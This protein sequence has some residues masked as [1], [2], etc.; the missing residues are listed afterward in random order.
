MIYYSLSWW[1]LNTGSYVKEEVIPRLRFLE[2]QE[3]LN[4][5]ADYILKEEDCKIVQ[6]YVKHIIDLNKYQ[7]SLEVTQI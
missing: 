5:E 3:S 7:Y 1:D 6:P 4:C 2:L